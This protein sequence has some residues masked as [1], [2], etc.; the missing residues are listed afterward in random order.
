M[1]RNFHVVSLNI[2]SLSS[3]LHTCKIAWDTSQK[4]EDT[5]E[6]CPFSRWKLFI[7]PTTLFSHEL[8]MKSGSFTIQ[9]KL[10]RSAFPMV[11]FVVFHLVKLNVDLFFII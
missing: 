4:S 6:M 9:I 10:L 7:F 5:M 1:F 3:L 11:V 8:W 2:N